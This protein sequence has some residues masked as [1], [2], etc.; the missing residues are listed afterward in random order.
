MCE[1]LVLAY[2]SD[3]MNN[4][5]NINLKRSVLQMEKISLQLFSSLFVNVQTRIPGLSNYCD[6]KITLNRLENHLLVI[7]S[8]KWTMQLSIIWLV[9]VVC[10]HMLWLSN[11]GA[12]FSCNAY[13]LIR[14]ICTYKSN[15]KSHIIY[16]LLILA[17][18]FS[19]IAIAQSIKQCLEIYL[20]KPCSGLYVVINLL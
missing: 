7:C 19:D 4:S 20:W 14:Y 5:L 1:L 12:L 2:F 15:G 18:A 6:M 9:L 13:G 10:K 16:N 11:S 3:W 17:L 8:C